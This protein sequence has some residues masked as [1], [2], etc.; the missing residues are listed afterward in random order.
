MSPAVAMCP[1]MSVSFVIV[2][3]ADELSFGSQ[4]WVTSTG[5][6]LAAE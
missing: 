1:T 2:G 3:A 6:W 5:A 4:F